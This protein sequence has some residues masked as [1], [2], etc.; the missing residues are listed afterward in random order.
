[1]RARGG[2]LAPGDD[3]GAL[4]KDDA[5]LGARHSRE[6]DQHLDAGGGLDDIHEGCALPRGG[7]T[8]LGLEQLPQARMV[9][10]LAMFPINTRHSSR[11]CSPGPRPERRRPDSCVTAFMDSLAELR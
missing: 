10:Q 7:S 3:Q 9:E 8:A 4:G 11:Y 1:M 2:Q 5:D 6:V